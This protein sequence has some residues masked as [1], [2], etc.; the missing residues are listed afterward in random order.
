MARSPLVNEFLEAKAKGGKYA[1]Q[2][3]RPRTIETYQSMLERIEEWTDKPIHEVTD[4]DAD[5][6]IQR[7]TD[8]KLSASFRN[9]MLSAGRGFFDW[10]IKS[11]KDVQIERNPFSDIRME[12][13]T[14]KRNP[15]A[16]TQQQFDRLIKTI[17][18]IDTENVENA[19]ASGPQ[20]ANAPWV[21][22]EGRVFKKTLPVKLM[23]Y[24]GLRI[25][26]AVSMR[27]DHVQDDGV[28][29]EGK[30]G[31]ERWV[32]L[33]KWLIQELK[34]YIEEYSDPDEPYIF[35]P[36]RTKRY[37][38]GQF[39]HPT[40]VHQ[41]FHEAVKRARLPE[42]VTPHALRHSF[43]KR[44]LDRTGRI[45]IVQDLLGH[46]NLETTRIYLQNDREEI[47]HEAEKIWA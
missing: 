40:R 25:T 24:G 45:D 8:E 26:E 14:S 35:T 5:K 29:I 6:A 34:D 22:D 37:K 33:P 21:K 38:E 28:I 2:K 15:K 16:I 36:M 39:L 12:K 43:A 47:K 18:Q 3:A 4:E 46:E 20:G 17:E 30:G 19:L 44:A 42:W 31:K 7:V 32:P 1:G 41:P 27:K 10:A 9:L 11:G 13:R 23:Y